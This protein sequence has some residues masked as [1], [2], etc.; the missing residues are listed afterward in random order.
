MSA[1]GGFVMG[2]LAVRVGPDDHVRGNADAPVTLVEYGDYEC[3]YCRRAHPTV[4]SLLAEFEA[5]LR[6]VYRHFPLTTL[7]PHA[8]DAA[9]A[10]EAAGLQGAFWDMHDRLFETAHTLTWPELFQ[11][12]QALDLDPQ[13]F[14]ADF[15]SDAVLARIRADVRG[16]VRSGVNGTP[17]FFVN[18]VRYDGP[19]ELE[20]MED[21]ILKARGY[22]R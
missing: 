6:V 16:G 12:A 7:H 15:R 13:R 2:R 18:G 14:A 3:P 10:A 11:H 19:A 5:D 22:E 1:L 21:V 20:A 4:S 8:L 17:T 9:R